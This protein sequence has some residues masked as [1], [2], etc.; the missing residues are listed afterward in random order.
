M[1]PPE[2]EQGSTAQSG[3][4][5]GAQD[6]RQ[7]PGHVCVWPGPCVLCVWCAHVPLSLRCWDCLCSF[8]EQLGLRLSLCVILRPAYSGKG[9]GLGFRAVEKTQ[10]IKSGLMLVLPSRFFCLV[11]AAAKVAMAAQSRSDKLG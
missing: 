4:A 5:E 8:C 11:V 6:S 7:C 1:S 9:A 10:R 2:L 3:C